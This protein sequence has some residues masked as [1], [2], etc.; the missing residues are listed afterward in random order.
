M[1]AIINVY[2]V[3]WNILNKLP[4]L[5][6]QT[7]LFYLFIYVYMKKLL[8]IL[9]IFTSTFHWVYADITGM[10]V[11][12]QNKK[13]ST[14][15]STFISVYLT[16]EAYQ[17]AENA[18]PIISSVPDFPVEIWEFVSCS[19]AE[20]IELCGKMDES[21]INFKWAYVT[22]IKTKNVEE[23]V[24][25]TVLSDNGDTPK[26]FTTSL[27][28]WEWWAVTPV[29]DTIQ[30]VPEVGFDGIQWIYILYLMGIMWIIFM[31]SY[32]RNRRS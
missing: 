21:L 11:E 9:F 6:P 10:E 13:L 19:S 4:I 23:N 7:K 15:A 1:S 27:T 28:I 25:I 14:N 16:D 18:Q 12:V 20:G 29:V 22:E 3:L 32:V 17:G 5:T 2:Y 31:F 30:E 8:L 26:I 24:A